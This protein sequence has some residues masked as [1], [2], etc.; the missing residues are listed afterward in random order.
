[1][2]KKIYQ[3]YKWLIYIILISIL[4]YIIQIAASGIYPFG[5]KSLISGDIAGQYI[6]FWAYF[7]NCFFGKES[8]LYSFE[9]SLG[10][11][12][13]GIWAYYLMSPYNL[14]FLLF[15]NNLVAEA[16][17]IVTGLKFVSCAITMYIFL[18][19]KVENKWI[20]TVL[21]LSYAFCG[22]NI[23][24]QINI[25]WIDNVILLPLIILGVEKFVDCNKFK[26]YVITLAC[27]LIV[28]FYTGYAT[29]IFSVLYFIYYSLLKNVKLKELFIK[30]V[31]F[32]LYSLLGVGIAAFIILPVVFMLKT[33]KG[34]S[35]TLNFNTM[36]T[37]Y[38][39]NIDIVA[40]SLIGAI[41][42]SELYTGLPNVYTGIFT[43][44]LI[45]IYSYD[46]N[47]PIRNKIYSLIFIIIMLCCFNTKIL[48]LLWHGLKEPVGF[49]YR[50]SFVFSFLLIGIIANSLKTHKII[51]EN[52]KEKS[53]KIKQNKKCIIKYLLLAIFDIIILM[54]L[55][56]KNYQF[57]SKNMI[58]ISG[59]ILLF[60]IVMLMLYSKFKNNAF[61]VIITITCIFELLLNGIYSLNNIEHRNR[62]D[63]VENIIKYDDAI[64]KVKEEDSTFYRMEKSDNFFLNDSMLFNYNGVGHSSSTYEKSEVELMKK[65]G[66]NWYM[67]FVS[68][69]YG[70]TL[71]TD[72]IFGIKYKIAKNDEKYCTKQKELGEYSLYK[73]NYNLELGF[74]ADKNMEEIDKNQNPFEIQNDLL[75]QIANT[76]LTYFKDIPLKN[77][78]MHNIEKNENYYSGREQEA[79]IELIYDI[80][81]VEEEIYFWITSPYTLEQSALKIYVNDEYFDDYLGANKNGIIKINI[82]KGKNINKELKIKLELNVDTAVQLDEFILKELNLKNFEI[83]YQKLSKNQLENIEYKNN[84]IKAEISVPETEKYIFTTIPYD[85]SWKL[86]VDGKVQNIENS[87]GFIGFEVQE[88]KHHINMSYV[89]K[90]LRLRNINYNDFFNYLWNFNKD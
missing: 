18:N 20:L 58:F 55:I 86:K 82:N 73:N 17:V 10:G 63:Y 4:M 5:E 88:G 7:K 14:I 79:Y 57:I 21:C 72:S 32:I 71:L 31:K 27:S 23:A 76:D 35:F 45:Q 80:S 85:E 60:Y 64:S 51:D 6:P 53:G 42:N 34:S 25:M 66:Y 49:P 39:N 3:K 46:K 50:Y 54:I 52:E 68:Y 43:L 29:A 38:Y 12:M 30:F 56:S 8:L 78:E 40:K 48:N 41:N 9:K 1:M 47:I 87:N 26:M 16:L 62:N 75:N 81:K 83:A 90:G 44:I 59:I 70:N 24:F 19:K 69:G 84:I 11:N 77:I 65:I 61:T 22:Y 36:F 2:L 89:P 15:P 28:N 67:D 13:I 33:G 74:L 37:T